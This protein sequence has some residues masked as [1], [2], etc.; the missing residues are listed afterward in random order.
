VLRFTNDEVIA[1]LEAV[2]LAILHAVGVDVCAP[3]EVSA[4]DPPPNPLPFREGEST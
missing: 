1:N 2:G 4:L 3:T